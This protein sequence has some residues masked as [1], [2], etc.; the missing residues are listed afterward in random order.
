MV[1]FKNCSE[2]SKAEVEPESQIDTVLGDPVRL[3][4]RGYLFLD[5]SENPKRLGVSFKTTVLGHALI[6]REL[7]VVPERWMAQIVRK[8][9][10]LNEV[11]IYSAVILEKLLL[12]IQLDRDRLGNLSNFER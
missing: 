6:Q 5:P 10:D 4:I 9:S 2:R 3:W 12:S 7:A 1:V 11:S 8:S